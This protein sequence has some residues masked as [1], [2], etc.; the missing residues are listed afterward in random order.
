MLWYYKVA[1]DKEV[2]VLKCEL[3][4]SRLREALTEAGLRPQELSDLSGVNKAS[5]SQYLNGSH[6]P[7]N[8]S[9]G[10]I[11]KVLRVEPM[12]LMGFDVPKKKELSSDE[13]SKDLELVKKISLL[14]ERDKEVVLD[15]VNLMISRKEK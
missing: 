9:S 8:I 11:G 15:M 7:S 12:W 4:A 14:S 13:A 5:I 2:S 10:K 6:A 1:Q 3:T